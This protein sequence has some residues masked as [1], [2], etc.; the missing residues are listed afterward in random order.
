MCTNNQTPLREV[1]ATIKQKYADLGVCIVLMSS[2]KII[3]SV[4][5][6]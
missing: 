6:P 4:G 3:C 1:N 2:M 5:A